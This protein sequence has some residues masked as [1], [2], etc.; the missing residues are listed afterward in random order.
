MLEKNK[1]SPA[2]ARA[3][4]DYILTTKL[5]CGTCNEMMVGTDGTSGNGMK[6]Y[7]YGCKNKLKTKPNRKCNRKNVKKEYIEDLVVDLARSEL[8]DKNID[9]MAKLV[10]ETAYKKQDYSRVKQLQREILKLDNQ[11]VKLLDD[12]KLCEIDSVKK[13]IFEEIGKMEEQKVQIQKEIK[14]EED[15]M[16]FVTEKE[17][18]YFLKSLQNGDKN[19]LRYRQRLINVLIYKVYIYDDNLTIIYNANGKAVEKKIPNINEL[20]KSFQAQKSG[21]CSNKEKIAQPK[22]ANYIRNE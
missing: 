5:F 16:F 11:R 14:E 22:C 1:Q 18:K 4:T 10:Y 6:Y 8:T 21:I 2:R 3:K 12:L 17:I 7:Y 9:E 13:Y 20:E 15:N 19:D